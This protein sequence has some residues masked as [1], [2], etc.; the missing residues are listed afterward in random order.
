[1]DDDGNGQYGLQFRNREERIPT[2]FDYFIRL[3]NGDQLTTDLSQ[4]LRRI[5]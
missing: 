5:G 1:M 4:S 2:L 3:R